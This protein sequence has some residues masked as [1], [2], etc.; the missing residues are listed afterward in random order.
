MPKEIDKRTV[1]LVNSKSGKNMGRILVDLL[2][3]VYKASNIC[4]ITDENAVE[5]ILAKQKEL[6]LD[7]RVYK[8]N[9]KR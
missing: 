5:Y 3:N 1:F 8:I 2:M 4:D 6:T 9:L 7:E